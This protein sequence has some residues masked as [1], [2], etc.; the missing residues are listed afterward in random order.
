M[1]PQ[2]ITLKRTDS[3]DP[4]FR[5][6]ITLLDKEL[7]ERYG[8]L[9]QS[10]YDSYN[11]IIELDTVL[12]AYRDGIAAGCGCFKKYDD[13]TAEI[14][15]M[16]VKNT[17]RGQGVAYQILFGL[18][19]WAKE[20]GFTN[21]ILETGDKQHEAIALYQKLGYVITPNYGQYSGMETSICMR[22][23]L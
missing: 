11:H 1:P 7:N 12:M 14:K 3:T 18:E 20:L 21:T 5:S 2:N 10:T 19:L 13:S 15:R 23:E 9:M 8:E 22:K 17:E 6:L 16:F 4:D